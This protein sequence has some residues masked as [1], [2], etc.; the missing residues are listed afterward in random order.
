MPRSVVAR[1]MRVGEHFRSCATR[2]RGRKLYDMLVAEFKRLVPVGE[3]V[4]SFERVSFASPSCLDEIV[5]SLVQ[6]HPEF[7]EKL[8]IKGLSTF[9]AE[10][11]QNA[12]R[13]RGTDRRLVQVADSTY[14][15]SISL[16][17]NLH[18]RSGEGIDDR[19]SSTS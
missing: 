15:L 8:L 5:G 14:A 2:E 4:L 11:L 10:R 18:E 3:V 17:D 1:E 16:P 19:L 9:T 7:A 6:N 13:S 12:L